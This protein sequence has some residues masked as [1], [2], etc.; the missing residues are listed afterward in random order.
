[1]SV[2]TFLAADVPLPPHAPSQV[3]PL[4][5]DVEHE[6]V[7]D[8][9]ADDNFFLYDFADALQYSG[10]RYGVCLVWEYTEGRATKMI[11]YIKTALQHTEAVELW[12]V[13]LMDSY[14]FEDRPFLHRQTISVQALT[15]ERLRKLD[16]AEIWNTPDPQYPDRPSYDCLRIVR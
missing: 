6:T 12:H 9:G 16:Y 2:C 14:D 15:A 1:M 7:Y 5:I 8:G 10:K 13:W 4:C 11:E 3:Y